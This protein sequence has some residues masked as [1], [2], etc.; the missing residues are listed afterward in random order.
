MTYYNPLSFTAVESESALSVTM[1]FDGLLYY[2]NGNA[3][4]SIKKPFRLTRNSH[5]DE[6][7]K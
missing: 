1:S 5:C 7:A 2:K 6:K 3:L 4:C